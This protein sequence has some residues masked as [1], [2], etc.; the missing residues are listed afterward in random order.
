MG[1]VILFWNFYSKYE[2]YSLV[3]D[4]TKKRPVFIIASN[5]KTAKRAR[6]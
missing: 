3:I 5:I 2:N 1:N 6:E 4:A